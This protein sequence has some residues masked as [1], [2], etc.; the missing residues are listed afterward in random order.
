VKTEIP[1]YDIKNLAAYKDQGIL[2]SRFAHYAQVHKHLH[3]AHK[4]SFYHLVFFTKGSG[5]HFIDFRRYPV[6]A[7]MIY[8]MIPG[9]V[10]SWNFEDEPD[11]YIVNFSTEYFNSF[12]FNPTY[13]ERFSFFSGHTDQQVLIVPEPIRDQIIQI[14]EEILGEGIIKQPFDNDLVRAL[15]L[16]LFIK[17]ERLSDSKKENTADSYNR[18][19]FRNFQLLIGK[20]YKDLKLPKDYAKLLYITPN[21]LNALCKDIIG[22]SAGELIRAQ[23]ILEA[24]RLLI[25]LNLSIADIAEVLKFSDPSYFVKFFKKHEGMT[26][27]KF[28]KHNLLDN[29]N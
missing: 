24:K 23:V 10:H 21:H 27:D 19:L 1:V 3:T 16:Q 26:P 20:R 22:L 12:V 11:G 9:Q 7:G 5:N 2:A 13:L 17:T 8:F 28:R 29:G 4:H 6:R 15:L 25:N 14:F 18:T